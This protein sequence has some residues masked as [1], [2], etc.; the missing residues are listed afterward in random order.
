MPII[1]SVTAMLDEFVI[2][3]SSIMAKMSLSL[4]PWRIVAHHLYAFSEFPTASHQ[5]GQ[6]S[7][8]KARIP[9]PRDNCV[10]RNS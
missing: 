2:L 9:H 5:V 1:F 4:S 6:T 7:N 8:N 10:R 3:M